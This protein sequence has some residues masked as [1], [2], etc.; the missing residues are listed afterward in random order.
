MARHILIDAPPSDR[1][2]EPP[3]R[4]SIFFVGTATVI[5]RFGG[6]TIL[7]DPNFLH[8]G[9]HAHLGYGLTA[10]RLTDPAIEIDALPAIDFCVLS[11]YHGDHF[12]QVVQERLRRDLPIIT[13]RHA[14]SELVTRGFTAPVPLGVWD[15]VMVERAG[16]RVRLTAM[17]GRHGPP[18]VHAFLPPV[19]GS[20][21]EFEA[22]GGG[23]SLRIYI[24]GDTLVFD[25]LDEIPR[26]YPD[27]DLALLHLGGTR[28]MGVLLTMDA[29]QG[30]QMLQLIR[31]R[32]AIPIHFNDYEVYQ[33]PLEDFQAAVE[34]AGLQDRV[35]YLSHGET[36]RFEAPLRT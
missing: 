28:I 3:D 30:V 25:E 13:T 20:M 21:L 35:H 17:P 9:D 12:D 16:R 36:F 27:V 19:I 15:Q 5:L 26:R 34:A 4:G 1:P 18:A 6:F 7:T 32:T 31:P 29:A 2:A 23:T 24:S 22:E 33:S 11:H 10:R 14:A 8:A